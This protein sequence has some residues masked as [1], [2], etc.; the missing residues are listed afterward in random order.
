MVRRSGD[1]DLGAFRGLSTDSVMIKSVAGTELTPMVVF[2]RGINAPPAIYHGI[3][4]H[5]LA[6]PYLTGLSI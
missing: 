2:H 5:V 3:M 6:S 1:V 4:P